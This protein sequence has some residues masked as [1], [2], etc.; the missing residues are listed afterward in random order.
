MK[1]L[2]PGAKK[3]KKR[4]ERSINIINSTVFIKHYTTFNNRPLKISWQGIY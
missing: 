2:I 3:K 1:N 4:R